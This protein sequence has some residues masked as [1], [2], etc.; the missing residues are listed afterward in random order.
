M[1]FL[2][3]PLSIEKVLQAIDDLVKSDQKNSASDIKLEY[4]EIL[5]NS[6]PFKK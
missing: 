6:P 4:D 5:G 3:K 2:E 1:D